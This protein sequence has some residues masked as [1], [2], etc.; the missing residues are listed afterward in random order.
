MMKIKV[1][2]VPFCVKKKVAVSYAFVV[3]LEFLWW[4]R[5]ICIA[6]T[7]FD[8]K[9]TDCLTWGKPNFDLRSLKPPKGYR[10]YYW[11]TGVRELKQTI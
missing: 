5:E 4:K 2:F 11:S 10:G 8:L 3:E 1:W 6:V 7:P 9:H